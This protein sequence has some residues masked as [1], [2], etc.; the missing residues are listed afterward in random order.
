MVSGTLSLKTIIHKLDFL[1]KTV[2][3]QKNIREKNPQEK[4]LDHR[5]AKEHYQ[6]FIRKENTKS[7][8]QWK[9]ITYQ[10]KTFE[11]PTIVDVK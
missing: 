1:K 4:I 6:S 2:I 9:I 7:I 5:T 3:I 8:K 10:P 11:N